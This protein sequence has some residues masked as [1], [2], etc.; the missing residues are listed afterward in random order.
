MKK[1][2][3]IKPANGKLGVL[4]PGMGAV[5][6][7]FVAGV[8]AVRQGYGIPIG[9]LTQM[10]TIRLGKRTEK[11]IP[12]IKD[13]VPLSDINDLVFGGWDIFEDDMYAAAVNAR[14]L[15]KEILEKIRTELENVKPM[16]AVFD[17]EYV[18]RLNGTH[19]KK[20]KTKMDLADLLRKDIQNFKADTQAKQTGHDLVRQHGGLYRARSRAPVPGSV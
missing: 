14:V 5:A 10:G 17:Q 4:T 2:I 9:S 7:T 19:V 16:P 1:E 12:L 6:T 15:E 20:A 13:F 8:Y 18:K 3:E 11:R